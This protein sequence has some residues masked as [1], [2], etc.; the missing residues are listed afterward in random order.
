MGY[1]DR[2]KGRRI[3]D[4]PSAAGRFALVI[5]VGMAFAAFVG[6]LRGQDSYLC[7]LATVTIVFLK[8]LTDVMQKF[9]P[10]K[11]PEKLTSLPVGVWLLI[12]LIPVIILF[13]V[14][15]SVWPAGLDPN[16]A[17]GMLSL[18]CLILYA[19]T[20]MALITP[21]EKEQKKEK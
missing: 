16:G 14:L 1:Q 18:G 12:W 17:I 10:L 5:I 11:L 8:L 13:F 21:E 4:P 2:Y 19:P 6:S 20:L 3:K 7:T 9:T 15:R